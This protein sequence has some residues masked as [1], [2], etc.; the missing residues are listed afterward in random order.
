MLTMAL[1]ENEKGIGKYYYCI[2]DLIYKGNKSEIYKGRYLSD[3]KITSNNSYDI[4]FTICVKKEAPYLKFTEL[5]AE[6]N[7]LDYLQKYRKEENEGII[8]FSFVPEKYDYYH[9]VDSPSFLIEKIYGNSVN[10]IF[11]MCKYKFSLMSSL[12][13]MEQML[14]IIHS[15]HEVGI[16]HRNLNPH[17]FLFEKE[18]TMDK[19]SSKMNKKE[20]DVN[21]RSQLYLIDYSSAKFF[22]SD[23]DKSN[24]IKFNDEVKDFY[25]TNKNFCSIW[26]ELKMEQSRRDDLYSLFYIMIYLLIGKLPWMDIKSKSKKER[27]EKIRNLKLCLSNFELCQK[28]NKLISNEVELFAFYLNGLSFDD[29]PN[30][31]YLKELIAEMQRKVINSKNIKYSTAM[32][33][34]LN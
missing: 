17:K 21:P 1:K 13:L 28:V 27:R 34:I 7:I 11:K 31:I 14:Q 33:T 30:Y 19:L 6:N 4:S 32:I 3:Y 2:D 20:I 24:H 26:A 29:E 22:R 12:L 9:N 25:F 5:E 23:E 18:E 15:L 16:I 10:T 8:P